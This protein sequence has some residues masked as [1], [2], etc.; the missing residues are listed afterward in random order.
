M[1]EKQLI[2]DILYCTTN[3]KLEIT[4]KSHAGY[5][6]PFSWKLIEKDCFIVYI[7]FLSVEFYDATTNEYKYDSIINSNHPSTPI[8]FAF[9]FVVDKENPIVDNKL[10]AELKEVIAISEY[11]DYYHAKYLLTHEDKIFFFKE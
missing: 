5:L 3:T 6:V 10:N 9:V 4:G 8:A 11:R 2:D 7:A 1:Y